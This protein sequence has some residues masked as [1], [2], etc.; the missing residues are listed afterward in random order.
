[1]NVQCTEKGSYRVCFLWTFT[2]ISKKLHLLW[3]RWLLLLVYNLDFGESAEYLLVTAYIYSSF[4]E[5][6][7][8]PCAVT[9][10]CLLFYNNGY[11]CT[12]I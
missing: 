1:M 5:I 6:T 2:I 8:S 11:L 3:K 4:L 9:K 10:L 7:E 12:Y